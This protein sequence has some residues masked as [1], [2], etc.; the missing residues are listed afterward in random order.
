MPEACTVV[1]GDQRHLEALRDRAGS[2]AQVLAFNETE[3][4]GA[5]E[6][7]MLYR[8]QV[9][10]LE[11]LFA[12]ST[13]GAALI[14]RIKMDPALTYAEILIVSPDGEY[15]RVSPRRITPRSAAPMQA[16]VAVAD[17]PEAAP[18]LDWRGTR[19]APRFRMVPGTE[20]RVDG[21]SAMLVDLSSIGAQVVGRAPLKPSQRVRITLAD[22]SGIVR[23]TAAIA[24][25]SFEIP[26]GITRYRA[27]IE[28]QDAQAPAVEA[29]TERH[30]T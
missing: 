30:K 5:L 23:V 3:A 9:V 2:D 27:G 8:P 11:R 22:H 29:F 15:S 17:A 10:R 4:I 16:P 21:T 26:K 14:N 20:A 13:R 18:P 25:A 6:A 12:A 1:I 28:F 7:I 19:R 24:W